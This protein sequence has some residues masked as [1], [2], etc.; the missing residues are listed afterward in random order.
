VTGDV[1]RT[2]GGKWDPASPNLVFLAGCLPDVEAS[3]NPYSLVAV[4]EVTGRRQRAVLDR[5]CDQRSV[6][7]DSGVFSLASAHARR[8]GL[9]LTEALAT[10]PEEIDG[11]S[12]LYDRWCELATR[13]ADRLWGV[14]ELDLGGREHKPRIRAQITADTGLTPIPVYHP[15]SDG[16]AYYDSIASTHDRICVGGLA[17]VR[18][19]QGVR[20]RLC[21]TATEWARSYPH[22]WTHLLGVVPSPPM[23]AV[24][25]RGSMDTSTWLDPVKFPLSWRSQAMLQRLGEMPRAMIYRADDPAAGHV[26]AKEQAAAAAVFQQR[27]IAAVRDDT[28]PAPAVT[29]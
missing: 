10:P 17:G 29:R 3:G 19:T 4:S 12:D 7:L 24:G 9:R 22:L 28:H 14:I 16:R 5:M 25:H 11:W 27:V 23:L 26:K 13:L 8:Y 2:S 20:L 6:L 21:W 18:P 15:L 1:V